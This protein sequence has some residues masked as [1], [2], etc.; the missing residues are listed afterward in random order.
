MTD[1]VT[2]FLKASDNADDYGVH[3]ME[4]LEPKLLDDVDHLLTTPDARSDELWAEMGV[5]SGLEIDDYEEVE[6]ADRDTVWLLGLAGITAAASVQF[7]LDNREEVII[8]PLAYREQVLDGLELTRGQLVQ[9]G[10]RS[11]E[12][13]SELKF[14]KLGARYLDEVSFL[15]DMTDTDLYDLLRQH[16]ALRPADHMIADA[17]KYV[18][19]M[20][21]YPPGS[22]QF[23][24]AVADLVDPHA[25]DAVRNINR[26]S[27]ESIYSFREADGDLNTPMVWIGERGARNCEYCKARFGEIDT[28]GNWIERGL[29]GADVCAGQDRCRCHLAAA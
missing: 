27:V 28:Y 5:D 11:T 9:A 26:R 2:Q 14:Q 1:P 10:K 8:K 6:T 21:S 17:T 12:F 23:K 25:K 18:S 13:V 24:G 7:A 29:P 15:R 4:G 19:R 20:T 16:Q 3:L 22:V